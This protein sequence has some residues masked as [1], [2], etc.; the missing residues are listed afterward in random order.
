MRTSLPTTIPILGAAST[1]KMRTATMILIPQITDTDVELDGADVSWLVKQDNVHPPEYY[2]NQED[3]FDEAEFD[4]EDYGDN[5]LVLF[6]VIKDRWHPWVHYALLSSC[7][8]A[9]LIDF[10]YRYCKYV[11]K[12][13]ER[14]IRA[15]TLPLLYSFFDWMLDQR[16]GKGGRRVCGIKS[17]STLGTYWK[18]FRLIY[19]EANDS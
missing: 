17:S 12:D 10:P 16:R 5:T 2:I 8:V 11:R 3:E 1:L 18:I 6:D 4:T 14:S 15:I 7:V 13:P 19:E 9:S